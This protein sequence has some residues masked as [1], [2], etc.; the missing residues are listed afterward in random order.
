MVQLE[1]FEPTALVSTEADPNVEVNG[2]KHTLMPCVFFNL[3]AILSN[4]FQVST[5]Y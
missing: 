3:F 5:Q 2:T 4:F 1:Q